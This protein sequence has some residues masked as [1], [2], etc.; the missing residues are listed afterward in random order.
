MHVLESGKQAG[1]SST[2]S[3]ARTV[4]GVASVTSLAPLPGTAVF[5]GAA[6]SGLLLLPLF[7][8]YV[9]DRRALLFFLVASMAV[10]VVTPLTALAAGATG[11]AMP[12]L[13]WTL[14]PLSLVCSIIVIYWCAQR[15]GITGAVLLAIPAPMIFDLITRSGQG[16]DW[17]YAISVWVTVGLLV[18]VHRRSL[19][20]KIPVVLGIVVVSAMND[21]RGIIAMVA[22]GAVVDLVARTGGAKA[23]RICTSIVGSIVVSVSAFQLAVVGAFGSNIQNTML[24]QTERGPLSLLRAARP[25]S[26]GNVALI[27]SEPFRFVIDDAVTADQAAIIRNSFSQVDRDPN[28]IYVTRG[29]L[30]GAELHSVAADLWMHLGF[31]GLV[32]A[33]VFGAYFV[34]LGIRALRSQSRLAG[35][36]VFISLR[37]VWDLLFSPVSDMRFWPLYVVLGLYFIAQEKVSYGSSR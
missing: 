8:V 4:A 28:S 32:L 35:V 10:V 22:A 30:E 14:R 29:V 6:I 23:Y 27:A 13:D 24:M 16:N 9:R 2:S 17:K 18:A 11:D 15:I 3:I 25:E 7:L 36:I 19:A 31:I 33:L 37:G 34:I 5:T 21:T 12:Q 1:T 26:G 20:W